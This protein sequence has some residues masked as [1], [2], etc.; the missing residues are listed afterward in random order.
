MNKYERTMREERWM[1]TAELFASDRPEPPEV[2]AF[3]ILQED[4]WMR[5]LTDV[6]TPA[7]KFFNPELSEFSGAEDWQALLYDTQLSPFGDDLAIPQDI[8]IA[9]QDFARDLRNSMRAAGEEGCGG[10]KAFYSPASF[11]EERSESLRCSCSRS[12]RSCRGIS[13]RR[14]QKMTPPAALR[15]LGAQVR[16][17]SEQ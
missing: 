2:A 5:F 14:C 16:A 17:R 3:R 13:P 7:M 1:L 12:S 15:E 10:C 8:P 4:D 11:S 9:A 6:D